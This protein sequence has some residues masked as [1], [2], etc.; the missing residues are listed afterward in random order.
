VARGLGEGGTSEFGGLS[1][2]T[3]SSEMPRR[4]GRCLEGVKWAASLEPREGGAIERDSGCAC[5]K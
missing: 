2:M 5:S 3:D 1:T 4:G